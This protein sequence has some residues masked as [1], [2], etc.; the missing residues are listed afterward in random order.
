MRRD[1][2]PKLAPRFNRLPAIG[3]PPVTGAV[4]I[5][6][7]VVL[8]NVRAQALAPA[9]PVKRPTAFGSRLLFEIQDIR[10]H[11]IN[12]SELEDKCRRGVVS[13]YS[14]SQLNGQ[15][16]RERPVGQFRTVGDVLRDTT[17]LTR[18][19]RKPQ[20]RVIQKDA[21]F[22]SSIDDDGPSSGFSP[23]FLQLKLNAGDIIVVLPLYD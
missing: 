8:H 2:S 20:I 7:A 10:L 16:C 4:A 12:E 19:S 21:V 1:Q 17:R 18:R 15:G 11:C 23:D 9:E 3:M 14:L 5:C 22:Q 13:F 6:G